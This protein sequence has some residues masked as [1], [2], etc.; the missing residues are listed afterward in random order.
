M[1]KINSTSSHVPTSQS[2]NKQ[3]HSIAGSHSPAAN[4]SGYQKQSI[5][6]VS[7]QNIFSDHHFR[8]IVPLSMK[9]TQ[10]IPTCHNIEHTTYTALV[11]PFRPGSHTHTKWCQFSTVT[12]LTGNIKKQIIWIW[13]FLHVEIQLQ[14]NFWSF[15]FFSEP[16]LCTVLFFAF[17]THNFKGPQACHIQNTQSL[18]VTG[19]HISKHAVRVTKY[20]ARVMWHVARIT[21]NV[22][23]LRKFS[24]KG[25]IMLHHC[26]HI[27]VIAIM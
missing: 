21:R 23:A 22:V 24:Q 9:E 26:H 6:F 1:T 12:A 25:L 20:V 13:R 4:R 8:C 7:K 15:F 11:M 19:Q 3:P 27:T 10:A 14:N 2:E 18:E 16:C 17:Y 5:H